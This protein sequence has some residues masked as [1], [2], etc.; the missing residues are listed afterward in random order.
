MAE[1]K[2]KNE[3]QE[4]ESVPMLKEIHNLRK[5]RENLKTL[6][7]R[8]NHIFNTLDNSFWG[9]DMVDFK[10]LY[11]SPANEKIYGY[12]ENEFLLKPSLWYQVIFPE[13]RHIGKQ[14]MLEI[15]K[16][17]PLTVE[18]RIIHKSGETR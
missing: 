13:D 18:Y 9:V 11:A 17:V 5:A 15:A 10:M 2:R 4:T 3:T 12:T 1:R 6:D 7:S 16:G 14:V 8:L